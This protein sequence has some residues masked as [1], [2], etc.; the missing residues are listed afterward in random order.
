[1]KSVIRL[2]FV[3]SLVADMAH[4]EPL[5]SYSY[6]TPV[7]LKGILEQASADNPSYG[8]GKES[9][10]VLKLEHPIHVS[11]R[12]DDHSP[13][14]SNVG[15]IQ[16][17]GKALPVTLESGAVI[18]VKGTLFHGDNVHHYRPVLMNAE[19]IRLANM[20]AD[21]A[22]VRLKDHVITMQDGEAIR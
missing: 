15:S 4:A 5:V 3:L 8:Y 10:Y 6:G 21:P 22:G 17:M 14:E 18:V 19:S 20:K 2:M 12:S 9:Y 7:E 1:M 16:I 11:A 13:A